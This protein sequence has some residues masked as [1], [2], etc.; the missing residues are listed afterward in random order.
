MAHASEKLEAFCLLAKSARGAA[1]AQLIS[2]A[3]AAPGVYVFGELLDM[4]HIKEV[5]SIL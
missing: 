5:S 2:E 3:T 1:A 4:P